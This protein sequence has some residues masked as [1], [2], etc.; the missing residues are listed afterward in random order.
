MEANQKGDVLTRQSGFFLGVS[1]D[2]GEGK[3]GR[4]ETSLLKKEKRTRCNCQ[5]ADV[6]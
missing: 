2:G 3:A 5:M 1:R 4:V 6:P